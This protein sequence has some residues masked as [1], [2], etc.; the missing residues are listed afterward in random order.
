MNNEPNSEQAKVLKEE[1]LEGVVGGGGA[2][3]FGE[4][5]VVG[6]A[7]KLDVLA[8]SVNIEGGMGGIKDEF[9][10]NGR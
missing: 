6:I 8:P 9:S 1:E 4:I 2:D 7:Q 3:P 5:P 10:I